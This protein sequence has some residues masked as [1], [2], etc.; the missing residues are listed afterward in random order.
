MRINLDKIKSN[1]ATE[2]SQAKANNYEAVLVP[3]EYDLDIYCLNNIDDENY[4]L[5][6]ATDYGWDK[7][8]LIDFINKNEKIIDL[9]E[10]EAA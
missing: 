5:E 7:F 9:Y 1:Y 2:I 4:I 6:V 10:L 3:V 8:L